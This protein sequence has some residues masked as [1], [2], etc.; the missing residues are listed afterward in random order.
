MI[1]QCGYESA[2]ADLIANTLVKTIRENYNS[3]VGDMV[4]SL[5][6]FK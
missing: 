1:T 3:P 4:Y 6:D 2:P 5:H